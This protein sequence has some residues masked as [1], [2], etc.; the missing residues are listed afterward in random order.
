[1]RAPVNPPLIEEIAR[2]QRLL[3][4]ER[5]QD[6]LDFGEILSLRLRLREL[7]AAART[8]WGTKGPAGGGTPSAAAAARLAA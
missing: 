3:D 2:V 6:V 7:V 5:G 4:I 8:G 1:M